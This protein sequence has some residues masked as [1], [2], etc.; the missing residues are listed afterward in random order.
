[1]PPLITTGASGIAQRLIAA[2][3]KRP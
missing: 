3:S 1:M 2:N